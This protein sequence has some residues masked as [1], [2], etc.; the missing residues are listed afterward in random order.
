G[1]GPAGTGKTTSMKAV[2]DTWQKVGHQVIALAPSAVAAETLGEEIGVQ[3]HTLATLTYP[4]RGVIGDKP[5]SLPSS[6]EITPGTMLLVD[7]ASLA[8]T[9]DLA[10][11]TDIARAK[12]AI[13][14]LLGDP[15]QLDAVETGGALR[16]LAEETKAPELTDVVRFGDDLEQAENS[17]QVRA[18]NPES[19][20]LFDG[21]G[22]I[23]S[24]TAAEMKDQAAVA[25]IADTDAGLQSIVMLST[26]DDVREVNLSV[27]AHQRGRGIAN[28]ARTT[29]LSDELTAGVGDTV[30]TRRNDR[31]L[32]TLGGRRRNM[33]VRNGDLWTVTA[34]NPDGSLTVRSKTHHG[35][36]VLPAKY[37][38]RD[39][40]LG[41]AATVHRSQG[42]TVD[43]SHT[44]VTGATNR[45]GL[46]VAVTRGRTENHLYVPTEP[47]VTQDTEG[48]HLG[49]HQTP[50]AHDVL[51][52][53]LAADNGHRAAITE[54]HEA[55]RQANSPERLHEA[56][57]A[58]QTRLRDRWLDHLLDRS[59]PATIL[60]TMETAHPGSLASLRATLADIHDR[61]DSA[62]HV[63]N[64]A[65][66]RGELH[67]ARDVAAVLNARITNAA[68]AV[69]EPTGAALP[70]LP[71]RAPHTDMELDDYARIV[72]E[73][74][75]EARPAAEHDA[76]G[77]GAKIRDYRQ[78]RTVLDRERVRRPVEAVFDPETAASITADK[79]A[80]RL[81]RQLRNASLAGLNPAEILQWHARQLTE[82]GKPI[83]AV[84][85][86]SDIGPALTTATRDLNAQWL[87]ENDAVLREHLPVAAAMADRGGDPRWND[88]AGRLRVHT[89]HGGRELADLCSELAAH[90]GTMSNISR[91]VEALDEIA[92]AG[93]EPIN[94]AA[95]HWVPSPDVDAH[96]VDPALAQQL[97]DEYTDIAAFRE[98]TVLEIA[99]TAQRGAESENVDV[100]LPTNLAWTQHLGPRPYEDE[101]A[102]DWDRAAADIHAYRST[103]RITD[104]TS[105]AGDRPDK[106][107]E[108]GDFHAVHDRAQI[109]H[110]HVDQYREEQQRQTR[111]Q[112]N[113]DHERQM[114]GHAH[115]IETQEN[116]RG[117]RRM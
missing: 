27:Q 8:S 45:A 69:G 89:T 51:C 11:I 105:L 28:E 112:E 115:A 26:G 81:G 116:Q 17:L 60:A 109:F 50:Q 37:V 91:V 24:G 94:P 71:P 117:G 72:A 98:T 41:Y 52:R 100:E 107:A 86:A 79:A 20:E 42:I 35:S 1:I 87:D 96:Q 83:T 78:T 40:E 65:V 57:L 55:T 108:L 102:V 82:Q 93:H 30:L 58:A 31:T 22:W 110:D 77:V 106:K 19:L 44:A 63:L 56:Y 14:R 48:M 66:S 104:T 34:V 36:I 90:A 25:Y 61:G 9:K 103:Y 10:A 5:G 18:G 43:T 4:W 53:I 64:E 16:L 74:Y 39:T 15:A 2:A 23:H 70:P 32:R 92:P 73:L 68:A 88:V 111:Q 6:I 7:E 12:G 67:T 38:R 85:L 49:E 95:P 114:H 76:D 99:A 13:V 84:S 75:T 29:V 21:R 47:G 3:A 33:F 80:W 59:L 101:L 46:Y 97:R 113:T 62:S 54:I